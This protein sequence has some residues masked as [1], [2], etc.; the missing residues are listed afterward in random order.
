M[1]LHRPGG[2]ERNLATRAD[3]LAYARSVSELAKSIPIKDNPAVIRGPLHSQ[4]GK[5]SV[6]GSAFGD[7]MIL[8]VSFA[9][10]GSDDIDTAA[11]VELIRSAP[12]FGFE[13]SIVD[14]HN[15][16]D[17]NLQ[18]PATQDPGWR[19]LYESVRETKPEPISVSYSH[20]SEAGF[21]SQG[22]LTENGVGLFMIQT[23]RSKSALVLADANNSVPALREEVSRALGSAGYDLIEFCTSDSHNLAARGMT[24]ERGYEALGEVTPPSLLTDLVVKMAKLA[25]VKLASAEYGSAKMSSRVRVFGSKALEEFATIAQSSSKFSRRYTGFAI[26]GVAV[27]LAA[28]LLF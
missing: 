1:T 20:S 14:A 4:V 5:A 15:S 7:D 9:P 8:T 18:S 28:S 6:S 2:H 17:P 16:I 25:E 11:E 27:L 19:E 24:V 12:D 21:H 10:L 26:L 23:A 13:A 22:D 3:T